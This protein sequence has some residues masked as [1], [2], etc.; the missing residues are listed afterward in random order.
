MEVNFVV[1]EVYFSRLEGNHD[2]HLNLDLHRDAVGPAG[3]LEPAT[4]CG[5]QERGGGH[6]ARHPRELD[7]HW[8]VC[9]SHVDVC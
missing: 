4:G 9:G 2:P 3:L 7:A 8:S 6:R 5:L 1:L